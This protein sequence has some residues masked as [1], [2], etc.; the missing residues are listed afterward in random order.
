MGV[1]NHH[2]GRDGNDVPWAAKENFIHHR[3]R[4]A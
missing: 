2:F 1:E 4:A 3:R